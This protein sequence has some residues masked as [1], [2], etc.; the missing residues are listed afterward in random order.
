MA[1]ARI[2]GT[3]STEVLAQ[4]GHHGCSILAPLFLVKPCMY[5]SSSYLIGVDTGGTFTDAAIIE[6]HGHRVVA[7][8]K[9]ITTKGDL[10]IGVGE[11]ITLAVAQLPQ[12]LQAQD[13]ALVSVST[14]LATNAVVEGHGSPVGVLLIGFDAQMVAR[15]GIAEAFP[16]LPMEVIAGGHD[17]NGDARVPLDMAALDAALE[18]MAAKVDAFAVASTF[19]VRNAAHEQAGPPVLG[20]EILESQVCPPRRQLGIRPIMLALSLLPGMARVKHPGAVGRRI[21]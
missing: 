9:A 20:Q 18:R 13:I 5:S 6:A 10:A 3:R 2:G 8:A 14:T 11:A 21:P 17:H 19:A 12:G 4:E 1:F 15:T 16:G 7:R